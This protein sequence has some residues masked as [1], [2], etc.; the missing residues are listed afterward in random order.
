MFKPLVC[1]MSAGCHVHWGS[2]EDEVSVQFGSFAFKNL[3]G[4]Q[5]GLLTATVAGIILMSG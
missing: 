5:A 3:P 2:L 1:D 4:T